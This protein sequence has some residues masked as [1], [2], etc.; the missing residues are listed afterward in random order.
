MAEIDPRWVGTEGQVR[1]EST[2][3]SVVNCF[4]NDCNTY[5]FNDLPLP[6]VIGPKESKSVSQCLACDADTVRDRKFW[7]SDSL[8]VIGWVCFLFRA[9]IGRYGIILRTK[10]DAKLG[11]KDY[12]Y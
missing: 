8:S 11:I 3:N 2:R 12:I 10:F 4:E 6:P 9:R 1:V 5:A 7:I